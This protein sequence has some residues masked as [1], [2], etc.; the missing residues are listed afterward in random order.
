ME[1]PDIV[2]SASPVVHFD[3]TGTR[4]VISNP[5]DTNE[6]P[7]D[8][9]AATAMIDVVRESLVSNILLW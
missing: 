1:S 2:T 7:L 8:E 4:L 3:L 9:D 6:N 5:R